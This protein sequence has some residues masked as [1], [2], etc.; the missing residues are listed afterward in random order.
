MARRYDAILL[1]LDGTLLD[2]EGAVRPRN[3]AALRAA[4]ERGV[5]VIV[6]TG[7][8]KR[9]TL[10]ILEHLALGEPAV[11]FNGA[12]VYCPRGERLLE[13]R[14]L[15][16]RTL[17][18][19]L[20]YGAHHDLMTL[21]MMADRKLALA[22]R[23][24]LEERSLAGLH[25]LE[26]VSREELRSEH[27]IRVTYIDRRHAD[28][29]AFAD[30]VER[31]VEHPVYLTHFPLSILPLHRES[32]LHA[33]DVHPPCRGKGEALR[34]LEE[35]YGIPAAR[36]VAVGDASNDVPMVARAG[37]GVAM[38]DSMAELLRAAQRVIGPH[39]GDA[40]AELVEELF[41]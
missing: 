35:A 20:A 3:A 21:A 2:G 4:R 23:D 6:V 17:E 14:T 34:F 10:P 28:S 31:F 36:V 37:L 13:E 40:I 24:E 41:L 32:T 19:A 26:L 16:N 11:V 38:G 22:P 30:E 5:R 1:D 9:A 15:S 8:S 7:R 29:T 25:G 12:A 18:R 39:E 33:V 27:T